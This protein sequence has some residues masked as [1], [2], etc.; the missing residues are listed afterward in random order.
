M[1]TSVAR[2]VFINGGDER[3]R[4]G[5][6]AT[7]VNATREVVLASGGDAHD[8]CLLRFRSD[9]DDDDDDDDASGLETSRSSSSVCFSSSSSSLAPYCALCGHTDV[10]Y[11]ADFVT[12][13]VVATAS[14]DG[15]VKIWRAPAPPMTDADAAPQPTSRGALGTVH[16]ATSGPATRVRGVKH[17]HDVSC[18]TLATITTHGHISSIDVDTASCVNHWPM[19]GYIET[20]CI[21]TNGSI[22]AAGSRTHIGLCDFRTSRLFDSVA[23]PRRSADSARSLSFVGGDH[24]VVGGGRGTI[25]FFDIR[26]R[27]WLMTSAPSSDGVTWHAPLEFELVHDAP[28]VPF[29]ESLVG[30]AMWADEDARSLLLPAIFCHAFDETFARLVVGGGPLHASLFGSFAG[31]WS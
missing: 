14:R 17:V 29:E 7:C 12:R 20:S 21:A 16:I 4:G 23:L 5:T 6:Y 28:C 15:C 3:A 25:A 30:A 10:V 9:R 8:V 27:R 24:L 22:I 2:E 11:G 18:P 1:K 13:D 26:A 19:R 31:V